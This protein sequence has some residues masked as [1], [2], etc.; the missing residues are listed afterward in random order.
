M[1]QENVRIARK[2]IETLSEGDID[3]FVALLHPDVEWDDSNG[4]PDVRG[5]YRGRA[6]V[7]SWWERF[8][9]AWESF[10]PEFE[11]VT[12]GADGRV[13]LQVLGTARGRASGAEAGLR[14]WFV[15]QVAD[16]MITKRQ[17]FWNRAEALEAA[18]L[19]E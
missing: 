14:G 1:S 10:H 19:S 5:I 9:E 13:V 3:A 12:E 18:G 7:R 17:L 11:E 4:F 16:G 8:W 2:S 6:Q 15:V